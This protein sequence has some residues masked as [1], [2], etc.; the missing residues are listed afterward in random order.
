MTSPRSSAQQGLMRLLL[1]ACPR[2]H[3]AHETSQSGVG[4]AAVAA[5]WVDSTIR[6]AQEKDSSDSSDC[7]DCSWQLLVQLT[8]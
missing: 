4:G 7:S 6:R 3:G 5:G 8:G 2:A 1:V